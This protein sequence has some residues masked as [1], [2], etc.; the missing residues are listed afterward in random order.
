MQATSTTSNCWS[1]AQWPAAD[2]HL[3]PTANNPTHL[4]DDGSS[5]RHGSRDQHR[6]PHAQVG[7]AAASSHQ[8]ALHAWWGGGQASWVSLALT[9]FWTPL[10]RPP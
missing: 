10:L 3:T 5:Y 8:L 6:A 9:V 4:V 1:L 7:S 2:L